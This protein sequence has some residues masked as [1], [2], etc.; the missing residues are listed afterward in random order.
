MFKTP[1]SAGRVVVVEDDPTFLSLWER[2]LKD[3]DVTDFDLFSSP[4]EAGLFLEEMPCRV[5]ISDVVLPV[6]NGYEL[7]KIAC[8]RNPVCR[9][10]LTTA[11]GTDLSRFDLTDCRFHLLHKPYTDLTALKRFM[12]HV[13][14]GD[15]SF[16][17]LAEDSSSGNE[18]YPE[19][20]EWKL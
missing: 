3:L 9:I 15:S 8:R 17:D 12:K 6:I 10:V 5:L 1:Q 11:Y 19:V 18:D 20:T 4:V 14:N 7:A 2:L 16:G 13:I